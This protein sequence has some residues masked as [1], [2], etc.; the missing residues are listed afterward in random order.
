[1]PTTYLFV[2]AHEQRKLQNAL[3]SDSDAVI[4]DLE[5]SVPEECK[6]EARAAVQR[7]D[8][9]YGFHTKEVWVR[10]NSAETPHFGKDVGAVDWSKVTGAVLPKAEDPTAVL[11]LGRAAKRIILLVESVAGLYNLPALVSRG[12]GAEQVALGTYDLGLDLGLIAVEDPDEAELIW[13]LRGQVV[14]ESRRLGLKPP[15]DGI[16]ARFTDEIGLRKVCERAKRMGFIGK[17]LVHPRQIAIARSV[18]G[19]D[20]KALQFAREVVR[21]YEKALDEGRGATQVDGRAIDK[22]VVERA[23]ALLAKWDVVA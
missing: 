18:F 23:R 3:A 6:V 8:A 9:T 1:M 14:V 13:Q 12:S 7:L 5:D 19:P 16:Y 11:S 17:L 21:A 15:I 10:V 22:P 20:L 4:V 2:P